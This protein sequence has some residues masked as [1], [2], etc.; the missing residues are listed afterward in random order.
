MSGSG[1]N[2]SKSW[3]ALYTRP[4][5]EL[6]AADKLKNS[7]IQ[8]Y[9]PLI[10]K[11]KQWSDRKKIVTE[12]LIRGYIFIYANEKE[13]LL[14][15]EEYSILKCIFE[16]GKPAVIPAWQMENLESFLKKESE[17]FLYEGLLPGKK[18]RIKA[19][20]FCG[21]VGI[22]QQSENHHKLAVTINLLNRSVVTHISGDTDFEPVKEEPDNY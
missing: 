1:D 17:F 16:R 18:V 21:I 9:L 5:H 19:G 10:R 11:S 3:F 20:P 13:R 6:R 22:I 12:P 14:S 15:L 8:Y 4:R 7:D 2:A